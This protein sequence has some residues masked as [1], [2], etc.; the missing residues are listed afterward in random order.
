MFTVKEVVNFSEMRMYPEF[1][2]AALLKMVKD[3]NQTKMY[4]P[5]PED[6][7]KPLNRVFAY[8]VLATNRPDFFNKVYQEAVN[9][10][11]TAKRRSTFGNK[12]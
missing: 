11:M 8:S 4:L 12:W 3:D 10:R 9:Q 7:T 5:D 1:T 6:S 2:V